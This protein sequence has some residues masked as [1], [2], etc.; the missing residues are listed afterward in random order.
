MTAPRTCSYTVETFGPTAPI[1]EFSKLDEAIEM[2]NAPRYG[3]SMAIHT[4]NLRVAF[5]AAKRLKSGQIC[6]NEPVYSWDYFNPW[7]GFRNSGLGRIA[8][9]WTLDAFSE[10]KTGMLKVRGGRSARG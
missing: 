8:G 2:A 1:F 5:E 7:G 9:R 4:A 10:L 3:L 6:I